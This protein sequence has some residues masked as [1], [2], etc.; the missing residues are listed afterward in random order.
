MKNNKPLP[1]GTRVYNHNL[2]WLV[3]IRV[4][5]SEK[6]YVCERCESNDEG[7]YGFTFEGKQQENKDSNFTQPELSLTEYNFF[8]G[9]FTPLEYYWKP[10]IG[11]FGF[12]WR[13]TTVNDESNYYVIT[14]K[15]TDIVDGKYHTDTCRLTY[16]YFSKELPEHIKQLLIQ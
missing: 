1:E 14:G 7:E 12:F 10:K 8:E 5:I 11:D 6:I 13:N 15:I 3:I 9:G 4:Y 2:G 16:D